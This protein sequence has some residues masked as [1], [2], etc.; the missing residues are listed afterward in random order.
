MDAINGTDRRR[1]YGFFIMKEVNCSVYNRSFEAATKCRLLGSFYDALGLVER[2]TYDNDIEL[3][4]LRYRHILII[5]DP[6]YHGSMLKV[7]WISLIET[8]WPPL[9]EQNF[10]QLFRMP[11]IKIKRNGKIFKYFFSQREYCEWLRNINANLNECQIIVCKGV[12]SFSLSNDYEL[13]S[14]VTVDV[15]TVVPGNHLDVLVSLALSWQ[16]RE[17]RQQWVCDYEE[18]YSLN[19]GAYPVCKYGAKSV[20]YSS[21]IKFEYRAYLLNRHRN[22]TPC[23]IDGMSERLRKTVY[24]AMA[25]RDPEDRSIETLTRKGQ[26]YGFAGHCHYCQPARA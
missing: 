23:V 9:L 6:D 13:L 14:R 26:T 5:A 4:S 22:R 20:R 7:L 17:D 1:K 10:V 3:A 11:F 24:A 12:S 15:I 8:Y 16:L 25:G 18:T 2:K 21:L 19:N